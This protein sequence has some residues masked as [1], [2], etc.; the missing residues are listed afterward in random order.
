MK[1]NLIMLLLALSTSAAGA[2]TRHVKS[3]G[4]VKTIDVTASKFQ[5]EP[6]TISVAQGDTVRLRLHSADR[7]HAFA[8]KAFRV[9]TLIPKGGETVAV[10]FVADQAGT[11]AFTCAEYCGT[12]HSGMKGSLV[13][14]ASEK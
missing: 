9:K 2:W 6:A 10:E 3:G 4:D 8:I 12:G 1:R 5:F 14:V 11:F 7:S 13:V